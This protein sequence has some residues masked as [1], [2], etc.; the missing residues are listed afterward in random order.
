MARITVQQAMEL[1]G[2]TKQAIHYQVKQRKYK[3]KKF[4]RQWSIDRTSFEAFLERRKGD[5]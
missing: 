5:K 4:G 3:A 1:S 2:Y